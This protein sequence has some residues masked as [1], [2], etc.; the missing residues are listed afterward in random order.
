MTDR[1][2]DHGNHDAKPSTTLAELGMST[3]TLACD[4][5]DSNLVLN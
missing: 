1:Q 2:D 5:T 3:I 4:R